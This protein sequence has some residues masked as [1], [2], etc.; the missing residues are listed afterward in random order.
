M[1]WKVYIIRC[2]DE[3]LYTGVTTDVERRFREHLEHPRG[4]KYFNGRRPRE[5]V[6]TETGHDR[7]SACRREAALKKLSRSEKLR[8]V[9]GAKL[10]DH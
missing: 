2:D 9:H 10:K 3:T 5:V 7:S 1:D 6:Y 8:L 4:A